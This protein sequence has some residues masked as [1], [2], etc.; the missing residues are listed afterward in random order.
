[1]LIW[2][3]RGFVSGAVHLCKGFLRTE[4]KKER[5]RETELKC[6]RAGETVGGKGRHGGGCIS[7]ACIKTRKSIASNNKNTQTAK[8]FCPSILICQAFQTDSMRIDWF[9][10]WPPSRR[11]M[12][13]LGK[14]SHT[15]YWHFGIAK[16]EL[17]L[18]AL[19]VFERGS[20]RSRVLSYP[21]SYLF[22]I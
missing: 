15:P 3:I 12:R 20:W 22:V 11:I 1:M 10:F 19:S 14:N 17:H 7:V 13:T 5:E 2:E 8:R 4:R 18:A 21:P 6:K 9:F 16:R